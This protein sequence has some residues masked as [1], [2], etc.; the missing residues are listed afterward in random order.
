MKK[1]AP[2]IYSVLILSAILLPTVIVP[3][4][5][6]IQ[7]HNWIGAEYRG[8]DEFH[9]TNITAFEAGSPA[10]LSISLYNDF[11]PDWWGWYLPVNVSKVL[12][13]FDWGTNYT[14][15]EVTETDPAR[16]KPLEVRTF[17]ISFTVPS[18]AVASSLIAHTYEITIEHI[19]SQGNFTGSW[20]LF[21]FNFA[22]YSIDQATARRY[23]TMLDAILDNPTP[24]LPSDS[25]KLLS[26]AQ[27]QTAMGKMYYG[28]GSFAQAKQ[29]F[30]AALTSAN[31]ALSLELTDF[32]R[33]RMSYYN[34]FTVIS[35]AFL[36]IG[37]GVILIGIGVII[38]R[39]K[40]P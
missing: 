30:E 39:G 35:Y 9:G 18:E 6:S 1:T 36:L 19:N 22:V 40:S 23:C 37:I 34:A 10:T 17:Q 4:K 2:I 7:A 21:G 26:K 20:K 12:V 24:S 27:N 38:K 29:Q 25:T 8:Y 14:S 3:V 15:T 13:S 5:A 28:L 11:W 33:S 16:L 31:N 32:D